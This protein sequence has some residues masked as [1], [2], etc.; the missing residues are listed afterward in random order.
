[1]WFYF[2]LTECENK[3]LAAFDATKNSNEEKTIK[4]Y[5]ALNEKLAEVN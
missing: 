5:E 2:K 3:Y 1:M 4:K